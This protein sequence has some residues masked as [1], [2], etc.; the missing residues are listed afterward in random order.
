M[1][2]RCV[3]RENGNSLSWTGYS[4]GSRRL[5]PREL[6]C[7]P[8]CT[9]LEDEE[10]YDYFPTPSVTLS[11]TLIW[12]L[13][14]SAQLTLKRILQHIKKLSELERQAAHHFMNHVHRSGEREKG[15]P[16]TF[17]INQ[18]NLHGKFQATPERNPAK[19]ETRASLRNEI[20]DP[21]VS[22]HT[23][24]HQHTCIHAFTDTQP[25]YCPHGIVWACFFSP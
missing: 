24:M 5:G 11:V 10:G 17:L 21:L 14:C 12:H 8:H 16:W 25:L 15:G 22:M 6:G 23:C 20:R 4:N 3:P 9:H 13:L 19:K 7:G 1:E 18:P 2:F